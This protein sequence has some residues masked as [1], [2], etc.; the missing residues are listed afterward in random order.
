MRLRC[1]HG[2][3]IFEGVSLSQISEF[4]SYT[5]LSLILKD[6]FYTFE[7]LEDAPT[8]SLAGKTLLDLPAIKTFEGRPWEVFEANK[9]VYDFNQDLVLPIDS[10]TQIT[11]IED[12]GDRFVSDG[13]ILPGSLTTAGDRIKGYEGWW[14]RDRLSW[15][16][17][18][19]DYV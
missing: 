14:S 7:S 10:V 1:I 8:Y 16:Y 13:L 9:F 12:A 19:I 15:L 3:F 2:Y 18:E 6:N 4:M 5:G 11:A 17:S